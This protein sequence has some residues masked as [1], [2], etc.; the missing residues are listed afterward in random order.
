MA[1]TTPMLIAAALG[2]LSAACWGAE[3]LTLSPGAPYRSVKTAHEQFLGE[4]HSQ[5]ARLQAWREIV[6]ASP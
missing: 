4:R 5:Q 1:R 2:A 3:A 6:R